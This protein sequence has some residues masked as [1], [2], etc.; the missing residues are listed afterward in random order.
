MNPKKHSALMCLVEGMSQAETA[1]HLNVR[2]NTISRWLAEPE[3]SEQ[4]HVFQQKALEVVSGRL[5]VMMAD[6]TQCLHDAMMDVENPSSVRVNAA[7]ALV[8]RGLQATELSVRLKH[9]ELEWQRKMTLLAEKDERDSE[10]RKILGYTSRYRSWTEDA[11]F[12]RKLDANRADWDDHR[13]AR[14][15]RN[16]DSD[17]DL[18][19]DYDDDPAEEPLDVLSQGSFDKVD[20]DFLA[21]WRDNIVST[22]VVDINDALMIMKQWKAAPELTERKENQNI[23]KIG[24][25][26]YLIL[27]RTIQHLVDGYLST[28]ATSSGKPSPVHVFYMELS[29]EEEKEVLAAL[30][31][32]GDDQNTALQVSKVR[33][34]ALHESYCRER[35]QSSEALKR[36]GSQAEI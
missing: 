3:F 16:D 34:E 15:R 35:Q 20:D 12:L 27:N 9:Q 26:S 23:H 31:P 36:A 22:Q 11:N 33:S 29:R 14:R 6:A 28:M 13:M 1:R 19:S 18:D 4:L 17:D 7:K 5:A 2:A 21:A 25:P 32:R 30:T 24:W 8:A 10:Y